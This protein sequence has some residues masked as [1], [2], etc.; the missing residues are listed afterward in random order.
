MDAIE[1]TGTMIII[2]K[3]KKL[4]GEPDSPYELV[5]AGDDIQIQSFDNSAKFQ[6][7]RSGQGMNV[8]IPLDYSLRAYVS[9]L[10]KVPRMQ[11]ILMEKRVKCQRVTGL[12]SERMQDSYKPNDA[13][14]AAHILIG[15]SESEQLYGMMMYHNNLV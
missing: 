8:D 9:V 5:A 7:M 10:Y 1:E 6:Q 11:V 3:L 15:F 14:V 12:L 2:T 4:G 13:K